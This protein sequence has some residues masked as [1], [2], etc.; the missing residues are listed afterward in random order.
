M[1]DYPNPLRELLQVHFNLLVDADFF[2]CNRRKLKY[3]CLHI[4]F[5]NVLPT[6]NR[7]PVKMYC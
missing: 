5:A 6:E 1:F 3:Y 2:F 7:D 4:Q